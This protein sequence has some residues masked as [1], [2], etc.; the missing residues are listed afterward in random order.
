M[1]TYYCTGTRARAEMGQRG[2]G[3]M[4]M[5]M[6]LSSAEVKH[7]RVTNRADADG[8]MPMGRCRCRMPPRG[9][10]M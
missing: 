6:A 3:C 7:G 9:C 2:S 4:I 10:R 5:M 8:P 1:N